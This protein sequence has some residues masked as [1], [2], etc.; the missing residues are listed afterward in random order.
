MRAI[1]LAGGI[2]TRSLYPGYQPGPK[3]TLEIG[4]RR[5]ID[6]V[7]E[8]LSGM[9]EIA[10]VG[11]LALP[12]YRSVPGGD[13][14]L[15]SFEAALLAFPE[16]EYVLIAPADQPLLRAVMVEQFLTLCRARPGGDFYLALVPRERFTGV[17]ATTRKHFS[18]FSDGSVCHGNLALVRP[19]LLQNR[20]AME[21]VNNIYRNRT[22]PVGSALALG[23]KL[24]L[25]YVLGVHYFHKLGLEQFTAALS[26]RFHTRMVGILMSYP[27]VAV[28][29]DE[30]AD[31]R[32]ACQVLG[33]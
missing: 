7:L 3:A 16:E 12:G 9:D 21:R 18:H 2:N 29:I 24:G 32:I 26:R 31:Y 1:V 17:F 25:T 27:E 22:S 19:S 30:E 23:L 10:I 5:L 4:G 6:Y 8:A 15:Q 20:L 28:D 13:Q 33:A 11:E 14:P